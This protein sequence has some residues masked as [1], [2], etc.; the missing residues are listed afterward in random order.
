MKCE[1]CGKEFTLEDQ[2]DRL[3]RIRDIGLDIT[4]VNVSLLRGLCPDCIDELLRNKNNFYESLKIGRSDFQSLEGEE[5][6]FRRPDFSGLGRDAGFPPPGPLISKEEITKKIV[7]FFF[8][9]SMIISICVFTYSIIYKFLGEPSNL[10]HFPFY[11]YIIA[12]ACLILFVHPTKFSP[13]FLIIVLANFGFSTFRGTFFSHFSNTTWMIIFTIMFILSNIAS[14]TI[15][16]AYLGQLFILPKQ[17]ALDRVKGTYLSLFL[18]FVL[19]VGLIS[20]FYLGTIKP[21][22][23]RGPVE[24]EPYRIDRVYEEVLTARSADRQTARQYF[25]DGKKTAALGNRAGFLESIKFYKMALELIP[26]FST[27]YAEMAYSYASFGRILKEAKEDSRVI[28]ENF[29]KAR[30]AISRAEKLNPHNPTVYGVRAILEYY[31]GNEEKAQNT[32][33]KA[34]SLAE[35]GGYSDRTLQSIA[36]L[37]KSKV[38]R[39]ENLLG[40]QEEMKKHTGNPELGDLYENSAELH[41]LL[42][43]SY[44]QIGNKAKA[45]SFLERAIRLNPNYGEAYL[46]L[47]LVSPIKDRVKFYRKAAEKD[48]DFKQIASRY[49]NFLNVQKWLTRFYW[50]LLLPLFIIECFYLSIRGLDPKTNTIRPEYLKRIR[51]M[52]LRY[53]FIFICSYGIFEWY[54]HIYRP[55]NTM[56]HMFPVSFPFF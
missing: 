6:I 34:R 47:A 17:Q 55:I 35:E 9:V 3:K 36:I 39:I 11:P 33:V 51:T 27:S 26:N 42:G 49:L 1:I 43:I 7:S 16:Y 32:L 54:I 31:M 18:A 28:E 48:S 41:N 56:S 25:L 23:F 5:P 4:K 38:K 29:R 44:Y 2:L 21:G 37:E 10:P 14:L 40:I 13:L 24:P 12:Y 15:F 8:W 53:A 50:F 52:F 30:E 20:P 45:N 19:Y 22:H 46:N